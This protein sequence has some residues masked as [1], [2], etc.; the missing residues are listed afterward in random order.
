MVVYWERRRVCGQ[1]RS[2]VRAPTLVSMLMSGA[3]PRL[4]QRAARL[5][6]RGGQ[7]LIGSTQNWIA[8]PNGSQRFTATSEDGAM[9]WTSDGGFCA[10][11][12]KS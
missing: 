2:A 12:E 10:P 8:V 11:V 3:P 1:P 4:P 5:C 9:I 7:R 6:A